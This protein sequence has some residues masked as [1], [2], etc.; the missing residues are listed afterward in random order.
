MRYSYSTKKVLVIEDEELVRANILDLLEVEDFD[1]IGAENGSVGVQLAKEH[2]PDLIICDVMMPGLDGYSV[3][4]ILRGEP[5]TAMIPFIFLTAKATQGDIRQGMRLGADDYLTKPCTPNELLEAIATRLEKQ[6]AIAS[7]Y[8]TKLKQAED[9]LDY[10]H[11]HDSLT[12]LPNQV[13]LREQFKQI[14]SGA[15]CNSLAFIL[16]LGLDQFNRINNTLGHSFG[17]LLLKAV[18]ERLLTCI[19]DSDFVARLNA[20]QF[21]LILTTTN[22]RRDAASVAGAILDAISQPFMVSGQEIFITT[23]IGIAL[24]PY[25]SSDIDNLMKNANSAMCRAKQQGGNNYQFYTTDLSTIAS[26]RLALEASL[27][28]AL[29]RS[30]FQVYYQPQVDLQTRQ[31]ISAEALVRWHH[32]ERG[33]LTPAEF[34]ALAEETGLIIPIGEWVLRTACIQAK[35]WQRN[36]SS[37]LRVAVNLSI[38]QFNQQNFIEKIANILTETGLAP[39]LLE[40]ELTETLMVQDFRSAIKILSELKALGIQ[41]SIDDFG[42]GYS[43]LSYLHQFPLDTLKIDKCFVRNITTNAKNTAITKAIIQMAHSLNLKV[44]AEGVETKAELA[45]LYEQQCDAI[46]GYLFS[47]PLPIEEFEKLAFA[48]NNWQKALKL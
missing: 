42:M 10:L 46:Q 35:N 14:Q 45:F 26:D 48:G 12:N 33:L 5:A 22:R 39:E 9:K 27:R 11:H 17:N 16:L 21:A 19:S 40:L 31:I 8:A 1:A 4:K 34:I 3:L 43:C 32:P 44:I 28:R 29:S 36:R 41:I 13:S 30:E 6:A 7:L 23:S 25:D 47:H 18:A 2:V 38:R 37:P 20:D 24:Y 15:E